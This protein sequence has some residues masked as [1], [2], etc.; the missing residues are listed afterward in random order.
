MLTCSAYGCKAAG[1]GKDKELY[2]G[3]RFH[4]F[5][6]NMFTVWKDTVKRDCWSATKYSVLCSRHFEDNCFEEDTSHKY[7]G[8]GP[9]KNA[10]KRLKPG[11]EPTLPH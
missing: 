5:P 6:K 8:R 3:I 2:K 11:A 4:T 9:R 1:S 7:V 10:I